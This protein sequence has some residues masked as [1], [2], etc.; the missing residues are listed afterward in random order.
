[1]I[2]A[3]ISGAARSMFLTLR[4]RA[5]EHMRDDRLFDDEWSS[6]WNQHS[7]EYEDYDE[8]YNPTFQLATAIRTRLIDDAVNA[9]ID[10]HD[11]PLVVELGAGLSTRYYRTGKDRA[12]WVELDLPDAI[13]VRRKIDVETENH[14]FIAASLD[15]T[16]WVEQLPE[17]KAK[18]TLFIAEGVSMLLAPDVVTGLID[19]L[20]KS[21]KGA[22]FIFD[23]VHEK[24]REN[25]NKAGLL[26]DAAMQWGITPD[27]V[28]SLGLKVNDI[29]YILTEFSE[30]WQELDVNPDSL[31][32]ERSGFVVNATLK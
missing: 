12:H 28:K 13:A 20:R 30:R 3:K 14:W 8:W 1:M 2:D 11:M 18:N 31:T 23:V 32:E 22:G 25:M 5:D 16:D 21:H 9:F 7:P 27:E 29:H 10:D 6:D 17:E 26:D 24:T 4:A 19:S 15:N